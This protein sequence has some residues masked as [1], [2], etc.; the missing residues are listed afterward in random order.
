MQ[1][2]EDDD[3]HRIALLDVLHLVSRSI[4]PV[5]LHLDVDVMIR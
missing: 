1:T 4:S 5:S 2:L 3:L